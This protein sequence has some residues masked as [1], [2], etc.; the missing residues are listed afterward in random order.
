METTKK[1]YEREA[2][3]KFIYNKFGVHLLTF[4]HQTRG[5]TIPLFG[6]HI[7]QKKDEDYQEGKDV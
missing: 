6:E 5:E 1:H 4:H 2:V 3:A 7:R